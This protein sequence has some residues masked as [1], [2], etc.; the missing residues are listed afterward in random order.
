MRYFETIKELRNGYYVEYSPQQPIS[1]LSLTFVSDVS[2]EEVSRLMEME[3]ETFWQKYPVNI[4]VFAFD[5][6]EDGIDVSSIVGCNYLLG[7]PSEENLTK[8]W[9]T[10]ENDQLKNFSEE[11]FT[12][13]HNDVKYRTQEEINSKIDTEH[14]HIRYWKWFVLFIWCI[15]PFAYQTFM[16]FAPFWLSCIIT[17]YAV[18]KIIVHG[19]EL[20]GYKKQSAQQ[21][22]KQQLE[23]ENAHFAYHCRLNPDGFNRLK[24]ENF[25]KEFARKVKDD[26]ANLGGT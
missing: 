2:L 14:Q 19:L 8:V 25:Q 5:Q 12:T 16:L 26:Y 6:N 7:I 15:V 20:L 3:L 23:L 22:E 11:I 17:A 21:L 1:I 13:I 9:G 10:V 24:I 18:Y 4:M